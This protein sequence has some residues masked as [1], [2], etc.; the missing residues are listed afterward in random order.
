MFTWR[1]DLASSWN[2]GTWKRVN[3][4][5]SLTV[6]PV[7]D[8]LIRQDANGKISKELVISINRVSE[9]KDEQGYSLDQITGGGQSRVLPPIKLL[10]KKDQLRLLRESGKTDRKKRKPIWGK[11]K[12]RGYFRLI[13]PL[14]SED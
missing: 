13:S 9:V 10:I 5:L 6:V 4:V 1:F 8:T 12:F 14:H 7:Y 2:E 11:K 3:N